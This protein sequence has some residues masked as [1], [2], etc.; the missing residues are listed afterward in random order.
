MTTKSLPLGDPSFREIIQGNF[1]YADK[2]NYIRQLIEGPKSCFLSRPRRFGKTLLVDTLDELFRGNIELFKGLKIDAKHDYAFEKHPVLRMSM[3]YDQLSTKEDLADAINTDLRYAAEIENLTIST[4]SFSVALREL[5]AGLSQKYGFGT[6]VLIDEY[7]TPVVRHISNQKLAS[8]NREV[9]YDF[10]TSIKKNLNFIR[11][12]FVTGVTRFTMTALDSGPNNFVDISLNPD[13]AGICGFTISEFNKL[14]SNRLKGILKVLKKEGIMDRSA[15]WNDLRA[16]IM[17][18]YDGYNWLGSQT[19]LNPYSILHF[20][21]EK[22]FGDFWPSLGIPTHLSALVREQPL[23]F[24][25]PSFKSYTSSQIRKI[26]LGGLEAV[27]VLFN[28]GYLTIDRKVFKDVID[29]TETDKVGKFTFRIPNREV[30]LNYRASFFQNAFN[31]TER[32]FTNFSQNLP[33]FLSERD[34]VQLAK[35]LSDLLSSITYLQHIPK[36][37][38]YHSVLQAAFIAAGIPVMSE[39]PGA[40]GRSDMAATLKGGVRMAIELKY[41]HAGTG[42]DENNPAVKDL[43]A[44]DLAD[45][46]DDA[47]LQL[48]QGKY[49]EALMAIGSDII[50]LAL[51]VRGRAQV[52]ARFVEPRGTGISPTA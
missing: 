9:L 46:L 7:D 47:E 33:K 13:Y 15:D 19:I 18:W 50:C 23:E 49:G 40:H 17:K 29:G 45:A 8:D 35:L 41:R 36:E 51:A 44:K 14:F 21:L 10:Y 30:R 28:S 22:N 6:V 37:S 38:Y 25:Q 26:E 24:M 52:S 34:P 3:A 16:K 4:Q 2:T 27:P 31:L 12:I 5:L 20:F 11:F 43:A 1:L 39:V 32:Y 42:E 48:R